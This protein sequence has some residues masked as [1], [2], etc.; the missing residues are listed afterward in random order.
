MSQWR[1]RIAIPFKCPSGEIALI[2]RPSPSLMLKTT[3]ALRIFERGG[4]EILTDAGKQLEFLESLPESELNDIYECA[5]ILLAD[6]VTS[7]ALYLNPVE[8][9]L[10]PDDLPT[11]DFWAIF[12]RASQGIPDMPVELKES[13]TTV[14][15]VDNFPS[16]QAGSVEPGSD[17]EVVQ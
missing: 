9:Q 5:R 15:A 11:V 1:K 13:E 12:M 10:S 4:S 3:R 2:R 7:P 8:D 6:V 16:E 14:A 17:S